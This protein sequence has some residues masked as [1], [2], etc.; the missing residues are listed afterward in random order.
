MTLIFKP[1]IKM[2][3]MMAA[4]FASLSAY[5]AESEWIK[6]DFAKIRLISASETAGQ[7]NSLTAALDIWLEEGWKTYWRTPGDAGLAPQIFITQP[8]NLGLVADIAYPLPK[9]FALFG[10]D[11]FG[12]SE[13]VILPLSL[14]WD[15]EGGGLTMS[16]MIESL[17]CSDICVP[18]TG[19][20]SLNLPEGPARPSIYAQEIARAQAGV[21]R[22]READFTLSIANQ[23][24][25]DLRISF[26]NEIIV[27]DV[28]IESLSDRAKGLSFG[29]PQKEANGQYL[30]PQTAGQERLAVGDDL[31]LTIDAGQEFYESKTRIADGVASAL[32]EQSG[33]SSLPI[34][35]IAFLGGLILNLMPCVLPVLSIKISSIMQMAGTTA[36]SIRKRFIAS[37]VGIV[38]SFALIALFLQILRQAGH[39]IGWGIQFQSPV[40][41]AVMAIVMGIFTLSLFDLVHLRIPQFASRLA[42]S[43]S[44]TGKNQDQSLVYDFAAGMLATLLATPCSAPFV[45]TAV[46]FGLSQ[47]D[48]ALYGTLLMMGVGLAAPWLLFALFPAF[49]SALPRPGAWMVKLKYGL[50]LLMFGTF[51]WIMSLF[52]QAAGIIN[53]ETNKGAIEWQVFEE[54]KLAQL[55]DEEKIIFVDITADWCITCKANKALVL[56]TKA[57][58]DLFSASD[59]VMMQADWTLPDERI[60]AFLARYERFGIPFNIIYGPNAKEGIILPEILTYDALERAL[61]K[62]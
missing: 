32:D 43:T 58:S 7:S 2:M 31:R 54:T 30:I 40:F 25:G 50:G 60:S 28:F 22:Q 12:Y 1:F 14:R 16:A 62:L 8:S 26:A 55:I 9:R 47:S 52:V 48:G 35:L 18:V 56:N 59:V 38:T 33:H 23:E 61:K 45:G 15:G 51:L 19:A 27:E 57:A 41:L 42:A 44:S 53:F 49:I 3:F 21:P 4:L 13:R 5:A 37:A 11:T 20:L 6:T 17:I 39:Q 24:T 10:L 29:A 36:L 34:W 46:S